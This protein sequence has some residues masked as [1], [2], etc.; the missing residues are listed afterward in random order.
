MESTGEANATAEE[1]LADYA[2]QGVEFS[3]VHL[4]DVET[5]SFTGGG[6]T[7]ISVVYE[8][9]DGLAGILGLEEAEAYDMHAE[10]VAFPCDNDRLHLTAPSLAMRWLT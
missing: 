7:D 6:N 3:Y 8:I 1:A 2:I 10:G 9:D 5:Y 4:G